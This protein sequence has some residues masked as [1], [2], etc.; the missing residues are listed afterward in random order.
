MFFSFDSETFLMRP[1]L[2]APPMVCLQFAVDDGA[3]NLVHVRDP[4]CKRTFEWALQSTTMT[5][6]NTA[7]DT[8]VACAQWPDLIP[9]VFQAYLDNRITCSALRA[10]LIDI[11][12]GEYSTLP[13]WYSLTETLRRATG[14]LLEKPVHGS[15]GGTRTLAEWIAEDPWRTKYGTLYPLDISAWPQDAV[16]YALSDA[17]AERELYLAQEVRAEILQDQFRQ[18]RSAFWL[19]LM[20]CRGIRTDRPAVE[21]YH[22]KVLE[23]LERDRLTAVEAG[24]VRADGSRNTK[25]AMARMVQVMK[26]LGEEPELTDTG[27][28][29]LEQM[30]KDASAHGIVPNTITP[31]TVWESANKYIKLDEDACLASGDDILR[32]YQSYGSLNITLGRVERLYMGTDLPLQSR[33]E[34][35]VETG[36]TSCRMGEVKPG[37]SPSS[38][39][40][41]LQNLPRK[42]GLR[43]CFS[44]RP[45]YVFCSVDY[46]GFELRSWAQVCIW[47]V[48]R[49]RLAEVLNNGLDP[50]TE[51]GA[52]LARV[53]K[54]EAYA[55]L[56]GEMGPERKKWF[57]EQ[58]R[59]VAKIADF[60]Y[61][62]GMGPKTLRV[63]A[64]KEYRM[65]L[66]LEQC[67][68]AR[69]AWK[70]E[71]PEAPEY[72]NWVN[73]LL[74][75][76]D[77]RDDM[78]AVIRHFRSDRVRGGTVYTQT[79]NSFFQ[80][81]AADAAKAAGF[82]LA[83]EAYT[84]RCYDSMKPS[85]LAGCRGVVFGHDEYIYELPDH[86]ELMH[87]AGER[88]AEVMRKTA[89]E[90]MPDVKVTCA[91]ALMR[92]WT[93]NAEPVY[94][95]GM[96]VPWEDKL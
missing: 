46:D 48:G 25:A 60:G 7:F 79:C 33:F 32:A 4:A 43:E 62:G 36:R 53:S 75:Y 14:N 64:R 26:A 20:E 37:E 13:G 1:G 34:P 38:W 27:V 30:K 49:S 84:G 68:E 54:A 72:F 77:D 87:L 41:Q 90:W 50:H 94:R 83:W 70:Q 9:L 28:P 92:R 39:G 15:R 80:G 78:R 18:A 69:D 29:V 85:P 56:R 22:A 5:A 45:G 24:L 2:G 86:P 51:L 91:P 31:Y 66:S 73:S 19:R 10:R 61:P 82:N 88:Q 63:Q 12:Q 23:E 16:D 42:E 35:L 3:P 93:K 65:I 52:R 71:W 55:I 17:V 96:L 95:N 21:R 6:H 81:L 59:Q 47:A 57:K 44:A 67:T 40:F 76:G 8:T 11:A 74:V 58:P 89:Q